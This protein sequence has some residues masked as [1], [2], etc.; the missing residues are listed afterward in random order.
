MRAPSARSANSILCRAARSSPMPSFPL[1]A[2]ALN[3]D[4]LEKVRRHLNSL[5]DEPLGYSLSRMTGEER[6]ASSFL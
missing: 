4:D 5:P 1:I 2:E 6:L 3:H